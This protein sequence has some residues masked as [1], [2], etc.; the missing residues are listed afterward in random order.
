VRT[1]EQ[2]LHASGQLGVRLAL[3]VLFVLLWLAYNLHLDLALA[4]FAAG[5]L[6]G[7]LTQG[8]SADPVRQRLEGIGFGLFVPFFFVTSGLR[9]D[10]DALLSSTT[11]LVLLPVFL[12]CFLVVRG[13]PALLARTALDRSAIVPLALC[14][15]TALPL[16]VAVTRIAVEEG[17]LSGEIAAS[18]VGAGLVSVLV[19]PAAAVA[20]RRA[21]RAAA[22]PAEAPA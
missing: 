12:A 1:I 3:L 19:F 9:L 17:E 11:A 10:L 13:A 20:L 21:A 8:E 2:T 6:V 7:V 4:G 14:S 22:P 16:L 5:L 18:L 15:A